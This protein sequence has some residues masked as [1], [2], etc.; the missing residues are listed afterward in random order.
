MLR[1]SVLIA[2]LA[3]ISTTAMADLAHHFAGELSS[4]ELVF[5]HAGLVME[6]YQPEKPSAH[7]IGTISIEPKSNVVAPP[8]HN[9]PQK[10]LVF[11]FGS[12]DA[13]AARAEGRSMASFNYSPQEAEQFLFAEG[14][15]KYRDRYF[16]RCYIQEGENAGSVAT[17]HSPRG[18]LAGCA[19]WHLRFVTYS[20]GGNLNRR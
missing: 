3:C 19:S 20:S 4:A 14:W 16:T 8:K 18:R 2:A 12:E 13:E 11:V 7:Y 6:M 10:I 15:D 1:Q 9:G 5:Y 17:L